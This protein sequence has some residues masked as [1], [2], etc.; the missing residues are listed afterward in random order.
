MW[1]GSVFATRYAANASSAWIGST[2]FALRSIATAD[3]ARVPVSPVI[4][5][6]AFQIASVTHGSRWSTTV[7]HLGGAAGC[8]YP[9]TCGPLLGALL[10]R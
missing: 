6:F 2:S 8:R 3:R 5:A 7:E 9:G 4:L 10:V 1:T